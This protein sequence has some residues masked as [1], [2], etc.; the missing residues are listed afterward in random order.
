M[1]KLTQIYPNLYLVEGGDIIVAKEAEVITIPVNTVGVAGRGIAFIWKKLY[2][3][4]FE[5]YY[6]LCK[7]GK[8]KIG[9]PYLYD[10]FLLFPTKKHWKEKSR[11]EYIE[12]GLDYLVA[13]VKA[14]EW[15]FKSIALP[16]LGCG[17]GGLDWKDVKPLMVEKLLKITLYTKVYIY[18]Q[19]ESKR[20]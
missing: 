4:E 9:E 10:R 17:N 3:L 13:K 18:E 16:A 5:H 7:L 19:P 1:K 6:N 14:R 2:P 11:L 20:R 15:K 12:T 8:I